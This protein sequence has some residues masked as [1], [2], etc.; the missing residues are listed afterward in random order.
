MFQSSFLT[1]TVGYVS[2]CPMSVCIYILT[3]MSSPAGP[4]VC[5]DDSG[6][7]LRQLRA[8][9]Q[10]DAEEALAE[11][12]DE[13]LM[14][15]GSD[16]GFSSSTTEKCCRCKSGS[17]GFSASGSCSFCKGYISKT[18][19]VA[20]ECQKSSDKFMGAHNCAAMCRS[21][22]KKS[23][24][25]WI[26]ETAKHEDADEALAEEGDEELM[27]LGS[28]WGFSSSTTEKCCRCKSGSVGWSA[29]GRCSFC[30]GYV[31]KTANVAK[32]CQKNSPKFM[33]SKAC[34]RA[35]KSKV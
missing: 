23:S 15:L 18:A 8:V 22:V 31:S 28:D 33:G 9:K 27:T 7:S 34:A 32:E 30:R 12:G 1:Y 20:S 17:I 26:E 21:K 5:D 4:D 10:D 35:C 16:W 3:C 11:E 29:S 24:W 25:S 19:N 2:I 13:E 6:I 14:T